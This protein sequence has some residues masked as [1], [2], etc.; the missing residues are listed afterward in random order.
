MKN[1]LFKSLKWFVPILVFVGIGISCSDSFLDQPAVGQASSS[2][3]YNQAGVEQ[4][5]IGAYNALKGR[6]N[7]QGSFSGWVFGGVVGQEAYKGSNSGDQSDI[8]PLSTF[9]AP[10]TNSYLGS[11]WAAVYDGINRS[12]TVLKL[13]ALVPSGAIS[14]GDKKRIAA[15]AKF[16]RGFYHLYGYMLWKNIPYIDETVDYSAGNYKVANDTDIIPKIIA[17][18]QMAMTDLP[19][20]GLA[21]G[22]ANKYAAEAFLGKAYMYQSPPDYTKALAAL[23]DV[24]DNG[25][26]QAGTRYGLNDKFHDAFDATSDNSKESVFATQSS[27]NDGS[28]AS[29]ANPDLVLNYPYLG[30][31]PVSCCGF[32]QPSMDQANS[33]RTSGGY[34]LLNGNFNSGANQL[35]DVAW[36]TGASSVAADAGPLD[37][38]IDWTIG[39]TGVPFYDWGNYTGPAWVRQLSDGGPYSPKKLTFPKSEIGTY[40]DNSSW[41]P[42]YS[43]VN[44]NLMRF[45]DVL[46]L[47]AEAA[48]EKNT[49]SD[50]TTAMNYVNMVRNRA[51]NPAGFVK[52]SSDAHK[53]D[54]QAYLDASVAS[55]PAGNYVINTYTAGQ[56][57]FWDTQ[58]NARMTVRFER[59]LELGMEG[60]RFFDLVRWG[61][62][63]SASSNPVNLEAAYV[64]NAS[65]AGAAIYGSFKFQKG[66]SEYFPIPQS[67]ID[68]SGGT[69]KQNG[70]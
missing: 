59:K 5:L 51:K 37:P 44:Y 54:W 18:F 21:A 12:N 52:I 20:S 7:W 30:S 15:E 16:L 27:V 24:I 63:T 29:N 46:L 57:G 9:T 26:N 13:L 34:P 49:P 40:T 45:S 4:A 38:R 36:T 1:N 50:L 48:V 69:L 32:Y 43:A 28:G 31:L 6:D 19:A 66:K 64:Y 42:G 61:D 55:K 3:L 17:D 47:A 22:R 25:V 41:T 11:M 60:H 8:N 23:K 39:R 56:A 68:L 67:Q 10:A 53:T 70:E 58:A 62:T 65:L 33:Y 2:Q 14:D 35:T